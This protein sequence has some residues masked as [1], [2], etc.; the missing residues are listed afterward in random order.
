KPEEFEIQDDGKKVE[1]KSFNSVSARGSTARGDQRDVV[2]ILDD[3][4][5]PNNGTGAIQTISNL[6][7]ANLGPG[8]QLN[9]IR[10]HN[11]ADELSKNRQEGLARIAGYQGGAVPYFQ[12]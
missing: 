4:G 7:A 5:I 9:V 11:K 12:D 2:L 10:L 1:I 6:F 8:D 3:A